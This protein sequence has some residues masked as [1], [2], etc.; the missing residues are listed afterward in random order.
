[1]IFL[2]CSSLSYSPMCCLWHCTIPGTN[3]RVRHA[4]WYITTYRFKSP[5]NGAIRLWIHAAPKSDLSVRIHGKVIRF[6]DKLRL[7]C[8][9][10]I[11]YIELIVDYNYLYWWK[12]SFLEPT[13]TKYGKLW[14]KIDWL[15]VCILLNVPLR[16]LFTHIET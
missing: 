5:F 9:K 8:V 6:C 12:G 3:N 4:I 7:T 11:I 16:I 14:W 2:T 13:F 15:N 10:K 1:M